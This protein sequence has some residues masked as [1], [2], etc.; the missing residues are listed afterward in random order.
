MKFSIG[1]IKYDNFCDIK[2]EFN[3]KINKYERKFIKYV[4]Y[5]F[6][7]DNNKQL[8]CSYESL[9]KTFKIKNVE[10]FLRLLRNKKLIISKNRLEENSFYLL[11]NYFFEKDQVIF[12]DINVSYKYL[13]NKYGDVFLF[14]ILSILNSKNE[15][16]KQFFDYLVINFFKRNQFFINLD[17]F[18]NII[19]TE[20][21]Y[22]RFFDI[23]KNFIKPSIDLLNLIFEENFEYIK[24]KKT[25]KLNSKVVSI[26]FIN[27][28]N[29]ILPRNLVKQFLFENFKDKSIAI[30]V[31]NE[32]KYI[33]LDQIEKNYKYAKSHFNTENFE[34]HAKKSILEKYS[35]YRFLNTL[36]KYDIEGNEKI[37][38]I[39]KEYENYKSFY[40][41]V[42]KKILSYSTLDIKNSFYVYS[43]FKDSFKYLGQKNNYES[44]KFL[45][46]IKELDSRYELEYEN[47]K[48]VYLIEYNDNDY[49]HIYILKKISI[50][51]IL[52]QN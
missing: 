18:K 38:T 45:Q 24:K 47:K 51:K 52:L 21:Q 46:K 30:E 7:F 42:R 13:L 15:G 23:E 10:K 8:A 39:S 2:V 9:E 22:E 1:D 28:F 29:D 3:S 32:L 44:N 27:D 34:N 25:E 26:E 35:K 12:M 41:D 50:K 33:D 49:C 4:F 48:F 19:L 43:T 20:N 36:K 6:I 16:N 11:N 17:E 40:E 14:K 37:V 5:K 31:L